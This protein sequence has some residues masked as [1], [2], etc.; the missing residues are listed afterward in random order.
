MLI[1]KAGT[2]LGSV[3]VD[4]VETTWSSGFA[5]WLRRWIVPLVILAGTWELLSHFSGLNP[6]LFP[7]IEVVAKTFWKLLLNGVLWRNTE[8]TL[9]RLFFG[10]SIAAV[11]GV[12]IGFAMARSR[13]V[14][15][16]CVP[17][18]GIIMPIPSLAWIPFFILWFGL[19]NTAIVVLVAFS[20]VF[21]TILTVWSATRTINPVWARAARTL[22]ITGF[23]FFHKILLP[24]S[25]PGVM[26]ALRL[27]IAQAWRAVIAGEMFAGTTYGLGVLIFNARQYLRTDVMLASLLVIG[28]LGFL[29]EKVIFENIERMTIE[30][31][32]MS[33]RA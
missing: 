33:G 30:R 17:I 11:L 15:E 16:L 12:V 29:I 5:G 31:W 28:P 14:E 24:A 13:Y 19:S 27:G 25:L 22:N 1:E 3:E 23:S 18:I 9:W 7:P 8:G 6:V 10:W 32:G 21:P 26:T 4:L 2:E 20:A